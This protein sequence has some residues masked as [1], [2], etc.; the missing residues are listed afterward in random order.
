MRILR[1]SV[2]PNFSTL[3]ETGFPLRIVLGIGHEHANAPYA[4]RCCAR[5]ASARDHTEKAI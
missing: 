5:A 3:L 2:Q 1:P 4:V